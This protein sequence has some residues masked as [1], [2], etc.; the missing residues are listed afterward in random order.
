MSTSTPQISPPSPKTSEGADSKNYKIRSGWTKLFLA[1]FSVTLILGLLEVAARIYVAKKYGEATFGMSW[2]FN[3][4]PYALTRTDDRLSKP[5]APKGDHFRILVLGGST[6]SLVPDAMLSESFAKILNRK[7]DVVNLGQGGHILN[8]ERV[9][10]ALHG[11]KTKP[12]LVITLDGANDIMSTAKT[13]KPGLPY[14]NDFIALAVEKP[15]TNGFFGLF[16]DSQFV[17]CLN[18]LRERQFE[19][20]VHGDD[21]LMN[22]TVDHVVEAQQSISAM[23]HGCGAPHAMVVQPYLHLRKSVLPAEKKIVEVFGYRGEYTGKGMQRIVDRLTQEKPQHTG[24]CYLING[25]QAFDASDK[26]CF[27]DEAHLTEDGNR[28]LCDYIASELVKQ[29]FLTKRSAGAAIPTQVA[30]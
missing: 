1:L 7:V 19:K 18:K 3:Y 11:I 22:A 8:Q 6:A 27:T 9:I 16:R 21:T 25:T 24:E 29:G 2:K 28:I 5:V 14:S 12:D 20:K 10:F 26:L 13:G 23:A 4:E 17:N 15:I 30:R